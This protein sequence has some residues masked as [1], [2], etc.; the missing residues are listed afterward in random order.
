MSEHRT[1]IPPEPGESL[2]DWR[3]R[4]LE[5]DSATHYQTRDQVLEMKGDIK[6]VNDGLED[7]KTEMG[8]VKNALYT[9]AGGV[10][11]A[12]IAFVYG[13]IQLTANG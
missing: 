2:T 6:K 11:L 1:E 13:V 10:V 12:S 9:M 4:Q 7:N 5:T 8:K 3:L